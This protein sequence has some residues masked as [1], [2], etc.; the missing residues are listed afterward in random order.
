ML[1]SLF[2]FGTNHL[3]SLVF[4][5]PFNSFINYNTI[6]CLISA[7]CLFCFFSCLNFSSQIINKLSKVT[8]WV[9]VIHA[10]P[11]IWDTIFVSNIIPTLHGLKYIMIIVLIPIIVYGLVFICNYIYEILF[12]KCEEHFINKILQFKLVKQIEENIIN[13]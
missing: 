5:F 3:L 7:I 8:L 6:F 12:N 11:I 2:L 13:F 1:S 9:F 4:D 10:H